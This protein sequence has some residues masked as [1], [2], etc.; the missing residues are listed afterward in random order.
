M[1]ILPKKRGT[2]FK[3]IEAKDSHIPEIIKIWIKFMDYHSDL[4]PFFTRRRDGHKNAEK[5]I[6]DLIK[7]ENS[8]ILVATKGDKVI[9][10]S[11]ATISKHPPVFKVERYGFIND[12]AIKPRYRRM[13]IGEKMLARI[14]DWFESKGIKRIELKVVPTNEI[15][16][17]FWKKQGFREYVHTLCLDK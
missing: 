7:S 16:Y 15:G 5:F 9:G 1:K 10:Y 4:D 11:I 14:F 2:E 8:L 3:I 17:S 6:R 12:M 13:G